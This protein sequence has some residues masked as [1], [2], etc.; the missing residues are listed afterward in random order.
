[1]CVPPSL[2]AASVVRPRGSVRCVAFQGKHDEHA[3]R[4]GRRPRP[5]AFMGR[6]CTK[7]SGSDGGVESTCPCG[8]GF[9]DGSRQ[10]GP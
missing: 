6:L 4:G 3:P 5:G 8:R 7:R 10:A 1:M 2:C 9:G